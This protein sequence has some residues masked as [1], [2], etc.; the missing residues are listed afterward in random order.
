MTELQKPPHSL[1]ASQHNDDAPLEAV[2]FV[3]LAQHQQKFGVSFNPARVALVVALAAFIGSGWYIL[4][5]RS[6]FFDVQPLIKNTVA[7]DGGLALRVGPR[8]L[9]QQGDIQVQVKAEGYYDYSQ[10]LQVGEAQAQTFAITLQPL[11]GLFSL[12]SGNVDGAEVLIDGAAVGTTPLQNVDVAAGAH[13][14]TVRKARYE[15]FTAPLQ[16]EGRRQPQNMAVELLP[17][18]AAVE[19]S[20]TPAGATVTVDGAEV[21]TTPLTTELLAGKH[22]VVVKLAAHKAWTSNLSIVA[23]Q[24]LSVPPITLEAADG[25]VLLRSTPSGANVTVD[26]S[27]RGQTPVELSLKPGTNH[28]LV[29]FLNG[30]Q[31]AKRQVR[32]DADAESAVSVTLEPITS[33]VQISATPAD[34]DVYVNGQ[35][36]G[37]ANQVLALLAA[38]QTIEVRKAGYVPY[39]TTFISRP[40][41]EQ[42]LDITLKSLEQQRQENIKTE[43][44]T[45]TG[46]KLKLIYPSNFTIGASRREAGRQANEVLRNVSLTKPFYMSLT[47]VTNAQ[48]IEFDQAHNSGVVEGRTVNN[49]T[50][51]AVKVTWEQAAKYCNWLS[52]KEGLPAYY[53]IDGDNVTG[54]NADSTGYRLPTEAEWDWVARVNG[55]PASLLRFPWGAELPPPANHGNYADI[56]AGNF[57]G[58][59]LLD[60]DDGYMLSAPVASFPANANG[61]F[62]IGGN[63]AEWVHDYY[64]TVGT[65][66]N[67]VQTNPIGPA[68]GTYHVIKGASWA[69][70]T[71]TELR[72]SFRDY[73][74][75]ARDDVG[76]RVA[77]YLDK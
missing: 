38:S 36:K 9:I 45:T 43:I 56:S 39:T 32:T 55:D 26:G 10:Q 2:D 41:L 72:L 71:V 75:A 14:L 34:A 44:A 23:R 63:V 6:V 40:G 68:T 62:D 73:H 70:G 76:F 22:D 11:P 13:T 46:Q 31:E 15:E 33:S 29:F 50:Q 52:V 54:L 77:R 21:G 49:P 16:I 66:G 7:V 30:Y 4:T 3:P 69:H 48:Y 37:K 19:L 27:F 25:L 20:T 67:E 57:L 47:E 60:Y 24:N 42:R 61:F 64:G 59:I 58:R 35:L 5:A 53:V 17:A 51:P 12:S 28:S 18:W 8:H 74:N 1:L 65:V